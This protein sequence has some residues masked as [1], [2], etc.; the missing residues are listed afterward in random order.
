MV[1]TQADGAVQ[2]SAVLPSLC[3][4][5]ALA[6]VWWVCWKSAPVKLRAQDI[7]GGG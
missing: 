5:P 3:I 1:G 6:G 7:V 2:I 4:A